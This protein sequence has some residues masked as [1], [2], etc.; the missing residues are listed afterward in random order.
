MTNNEDQTN[1]IESTQDNLQTDYHFPSAVYIV[2]KED[3]LEDVSIIAN[4][5]LE[6]IKEKFPQ[7]NEIYPVYQTGPLFNDEKILP[8]CEYIGQTAWNILQAQGF[9]MDNLLTSIDEMWCQEH[10]KYSG[11]EEHVH[12]FGAQLVG[13]YFLETPENCSNVVIHDPRPA[14]RQINLMEK[15]INDVTFASN[16]IHYVP[17]PGMLLFANSWLPHSFSRNASEKSMK[18][19]HFTIG[20]RPNM[21]ACPTP[22]NSPEII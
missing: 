22:E 1:S 19:I 20:I 9:N 17:R 11:H 4:N 10:Y 7:P 3:F 6:I 8:L 18:F 21:Q 12:G 2:H 13:F 16:S 5:A 15:N 14:K